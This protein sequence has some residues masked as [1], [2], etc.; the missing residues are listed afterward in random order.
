V[1]CNGVC[2]KVDVVTRAAKSQQ[3]QVVCLASFVFTTQHIRGERQTFVKPQQQTK[4]GIRPSVD[5]VCRPTQP[6]KILFVHQ[7]ANPK[8]FSFISVGLQTTV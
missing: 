6:E 7:P 2:C 1:Q 5:A 3:R 8:R 4:G